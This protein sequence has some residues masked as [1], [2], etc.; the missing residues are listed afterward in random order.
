MGTEKSY[1]IEKEYLRKNMLFLFGLIVFYACWVMDFNIIKSI[2]LITFFALV[3]VAARSWEDEGLWYTKK[4][5]V[6]NYEVE[7]CLGNS[8]KTS[9]KER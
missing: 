9:K 4:I 5:P 8:R 3:Y 1:Y 6:K 7:E 2:L